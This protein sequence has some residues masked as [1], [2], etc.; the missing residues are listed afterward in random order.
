MLIKIYIRI[1]ENNIQKDPN[2]PITKQKRYKSKKQYAYQYNT[3][4]QLIQNRTGEIDGK[5]FDQYI[6]YYWIW[7]TVWI[8]NLQIF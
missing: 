8:Y 2:A 3:R 6:C 4:T 1:L 5:D 7:T